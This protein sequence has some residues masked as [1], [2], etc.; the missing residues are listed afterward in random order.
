MEKLYHLP[1]T[2]GDDALF[3]SWINY[4]DSLSVEKIDVD[5]VNAYVAAV[6]YLYFNAGAQ[7]LNRQELIELFDVCPEMFEIA[8]N[9]LLSI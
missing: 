5:E 3:L 9:W 7:S 2:K 8:L 6:T 1:K 4:A